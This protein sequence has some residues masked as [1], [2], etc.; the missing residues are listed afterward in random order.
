MWRGSNVDPFTWGWKVM[1]CIMIP[2]PMQQVP[3]PPELLKIFRCDCKAVCK[4]VRCTYVKMDSSVCKYVL[5]VEVYLVN[6]QE[7]NLNSDEDD[8]I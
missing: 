7:S 2:I 3:T 4:N 6:S 5:S 8:V 1:S